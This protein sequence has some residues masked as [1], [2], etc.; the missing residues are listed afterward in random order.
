MSSVGT[1]RLVKE[2]CNRL[3]QSR[4][5]C[6]LDRVSAVSHHCIPERPVSADG[7]GT[8][9]LDG[10][11]HQRGNGSCVRENESLTN[12]PESVGIHHSS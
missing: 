11:N 5:N 7:V 3:R 8:D 4:I 10:R 12:V 6:W 1:S 9:G 2:L